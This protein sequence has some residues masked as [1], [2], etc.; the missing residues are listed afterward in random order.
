MNPTTASTKW[1]VLTLVVIVSLPAAALRMLEEPRTAGELKSTDAHAPLAQDH[2]DR[3]TGPR[4]L[5]RED[6]VAPREP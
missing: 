6:C 3:R 1:I 5:S 4:S 2:C